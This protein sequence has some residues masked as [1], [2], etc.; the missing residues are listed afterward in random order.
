MDKSRGA[1]PVLDLAAVVILALE[2]ALVAV[3]ALGY[4]T[5]SLVDRS[6]TGLGLSLALVAAILAA[7]LGVFTRGYAKRRRYALGGAL[8]WQ[9]MQASVGVWLMGTLPVVGAALIVT[10]AIVA[11]AVFRRQAALGRVDLDA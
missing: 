5:Y 2:T 9:L 7:G 4:A 3:I 10:A 11:V 1:A 6:Y 8:T